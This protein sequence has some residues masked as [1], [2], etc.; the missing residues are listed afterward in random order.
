MVENY[1]FKLFN[2]VNEMVESIKELDKIYGLSRNAAGYSWKWISKGCKSYKEV[3]NNNLEDININGYKYV[4]NMTNEEFI[5]SKN[6]I[7]EIGC[8]HT[9]QGYD[10]N[11]VGVILGEE[12]DYDFALNTI[13]VNLD[14][15][16]DKYVKNGTSYD[17]VKMYIINAYKVMMSRGIKGCYVYACNSNLREYLRRFINN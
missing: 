2:D 1:D 12:I 9:L 16:Y 15:F 17:S 6:S 14:K 11:Y 7:N 13:T 10:L 8:I 4:W 5:L 3:I